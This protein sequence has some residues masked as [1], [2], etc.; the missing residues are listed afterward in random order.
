[1][2]FS[3]ELS[4]RVAT[5]GRGVRGLAPGQ[6]VTVAPLFNC[7]NCPACLGGNEHLCPQRVIFGT[8]VDGG[9]QER[10]CLPACRAIPL[11][12]TL[13]LREG[14]LVEPAAIAVHAVRRAEP[15]EGCDVAVFGAGAIGLLIGQVA[16][17]RGA[18][19][20]LMVDLDPD[21]LR[22]AASLGFPT[23][24]AH[25]VDL[26]AAMLSQTDRRGVAVVFEASGDPEV[27]R[28]FPALLAPG[29]LIVAV[30]HT[31]GPVPLDLDALLL[32]E[33][34]LATSRYFTLADFQA[35]LHL[36]AAGQVTVRPLIQ[37]EIPLDRLG[38]DRG[39]PAMEAAQQ[40]VRLL[41]R[42]GGEDRLGK[43]PEGLSAPTQSL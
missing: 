8:Q 30:G 19:R 34:R 13:S 12:S 1:M 17:A 37:G 29:G 16:R 4:G 25:R 41:V 40:A 3:H 38:D 5:V 35:S 27:W 14:A 22:L 11:P 28:L 6:A 32:K 7:G 39:R 21:R 26:V 10:L 18:G 2:V 24:D 31:H 20:I 43:S 33:A 23:A 42:L 9:L 15:L 36:L